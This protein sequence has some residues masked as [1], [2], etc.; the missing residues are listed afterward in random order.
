MK[1]LLVRVPIQPCEVMKQV[2]FSYFAEPVGL[3]YLAEAL[4]AVGMES[5]I[6]DMFLDA[7]P[8]SFMA[9]VSGDRPDVVGFSSLILGYDN[10]RLLAG[11]VKARFPEAVVVVGGPCTFMPPRVLMERGSAIDYLIKGEGEE[12]FPRLC[13]V[14]AGSKQEGLADIDALTWRDGRRIV[15]NPRR[16]FVDPGAISYPLDRYRDYNDAMAGSIMTV[17]MGE[18]PIAFIEA[19]RGC[20]FSCS[21]CGVH[22]PYR[23]RPPEKVVEEMGELYRRH[24]VRK[25]V[26][27]DYTLTADQ[28]HAEL[29]CRLIIQSGLPVEWG[30]DTR[31]DCVTPQLLKLMKRA[32]CR[33]IFY[34]VESFHDQTLTLYNK[35]TDAATIKKALRDTRRAGIRTLAYMMLGGPG[36]SREMIRDN[37]ATLNSLGV[38]YA[39]AG[40]TRLFCGT[41]LFEQAVERGVIDRRQGEDC[42]L[43]GL[44]DWIPVWEERLG[45]AE[46]KELEAEVVKSF[47]YRPGYVWQRLRGV[48]DGAELWRMTRVLARFTAGRFSRTC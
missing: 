7:D 23:T 47:Y 30:C 39:L 45:Y 21:F 2:T 3:H 36:E 9:V 10:V 20:P 31:V 32:G 44:I 42:C 35:G 37:S 40:I 16:R 34:G 1:V 5:R 18:P 33:V 26:F 29:L 15:E 41:A 38:D 28:G 25:F 48:R 24:G 22:E 27:G 14:I 13:R 43:S 6:H 11:L 12:S 8:D 46:L 19:S 4:D 17:M